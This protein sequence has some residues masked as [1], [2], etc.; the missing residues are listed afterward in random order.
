MTRLPLMLATINCN[1]ERD[2]VCGT[3]GMTYNNEC[4]LCAEILSSNVIGLHPG[5][6]SLPKRRL[7]K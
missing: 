6:G 7:R 5:S 3:D 2:P 4:F 1:K